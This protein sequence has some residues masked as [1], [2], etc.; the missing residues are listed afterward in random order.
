MKDDDMSE[1][2]DLTVVDHAGGRRITPRLQEI[3]DTAARRFWEKGYDATSVQDIAGQIGIL[4]GSL[5]YY[6][7]SKEDLLFGV[8]E[9]LH[10][11][12]ID[13][14]VE[15]PEQTGD[16]SLVRLRA[17]VERHFVAV[18][19]NVEAALVFYRDFQSLGRERR[20]E[21]LA[22]R[23]EYA[24]HLKRLIAEAQET[25]LACPDIDPRFAATAMLSAL[26]SIALWYRP[27]PESSPWFV[28]NSYADFLVGA[29]ACSPEE[30]A[31]GHRRA[32]GA[33]VRTAHGGDADAP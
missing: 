33:V 27:D 5:Y 8:L 28:A 3:L 14:V 24:A 30:H 23:D 22:Q 1:E 29:L 12:I 16:D 25:G 15:D 18:A 9:H 6:I 26:N 13:S 11:C 7:D 2:I 20:D 17:F 31:P 21:I 19:D 4:K 10:A 32:L